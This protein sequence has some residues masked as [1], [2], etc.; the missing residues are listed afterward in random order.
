MASRYLLIICAIFSG[1]ICFS[2]TDNREIDTLL[3]QAKSY[4]RSNQDSAIYFSELAYNKAVLSEDV[5][6][7]AAT[8]YYYSFYLISNQQMEKAQKLLDYNIANF[9]ALSESLKGNTA[10]NQAAIFDLKEEFD[11]ALEWYFQSK[12][13]YEE[14]NNTQGLARALLQIGVIYEK[15]N[16]IELAD[17]F[18]DL[19]LATSGYSK[20][21][22]ERDIPRGANREE[23]ITA[24]KRMLAEIE[25]SD[26][27]KLKSIVYYNLGSQYQED[28]YYENAVENL[29]NSIRLKKKTGYVSQLDKLYTKLG[30]SYLGLD[31][32]DTAISHFNTA[33][34][35][36]SKR[37]EQAKLYSLLSKTYEEKGDFKQALNFANQFKFISDSIATFA[38]NE[39]IAEI[40]AKYETEKQAKEIIELKQINQEQDLLIATNENKMWRW[41]IA[42][43]LATLIAVWLGRRFMQSQKRI[44]QVEYEKEEIS[45]KVEQLALILNNKSKVYLENLKFIKSDGNYLEF[46]TDEKTII[47]RNK[48]KDILE[49][50][51]PNFV[52]V[53][54]SYIINKNFI[55]A[56]NSASVT[57]QENIQI[58]LSRIF[59]NNLA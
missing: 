57:L 35:L 36:T 45:R 51:P 43:L 33:I 1:F 53:H 48:L 58:P 8:G 2:Q 49:E 14:A 56:V 26:N 54:R 22:T 20:E 29:T 19:S 17:H 50:L 7:K 27:D 11:L 16:K 13:Y 9:D 34:D 37:Q 41:S 40:T 21:N 59:K 4:S 28:G 15:L 25:S 18:F 10:F 47:D 5:F 42:A 44:K 55:S 52:K 32:F 12:A 3:Q 6:L 30:L 38:E 31:N 39:K 23:F 24:S 46:V